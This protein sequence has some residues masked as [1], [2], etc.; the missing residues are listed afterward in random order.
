MQYQLAQDTLTW[1]FDLV[2][3]ISLLIFFASYAQELPT[4]YVQQMVSDQV[5]TDG[6]LRQS[7][8]NLWETQQ[9]LKQTHQEF[10]EAQQSLEQAYQVNLQMQIR[11]DAL[12][13]ELQQAKHEANQFQQERSHFKAQ[14]SL[15][16]KQFQQSQEELEKTREGVQG[17]VNQLFCLD[18]K[19]KVKFNN[20]F[21][22]KTNKAMQVATE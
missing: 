2:T 6:K 9:K 15:A 16:E 3:L 11:L 18:R 8:Q 1:L 22:Q 19:A 20:F 13:L 17:V 5:S 10:Q 21:N 14:L 7:Q 12:S 4:R